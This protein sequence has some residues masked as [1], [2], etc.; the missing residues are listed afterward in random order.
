VAPAS[1]ADLE[2]AHTNQSLGNGHFEDFQTSNVAKKY[3]TAQ[4]I[5]ISNGTSRRS[6]SQEFVYP[7]RSLRFLDQVNQRAAD[8]SDCS[9]PV[10]AS[11]PLKIIIAGAG[12]GGL[13][14]AIALARSGHS[15]QV[16]E[17]AR[18]L[19]EVRQCFA[20]GLTK[21]AY[22]SQQVGAG[23]QIPSN[24]TRILLK[25]G[26]GPHLAA[27]VVEPESINFRR[28]EDGNI[29]G[30]TK[31]TPDFRQSFD[32]PYYVVHRAHFHN[33]MYQL[34]KELGVEVVLDAKISYYD[35]EA[36]AVE[37]E[38]GRIHK[39]DLVIAADGKS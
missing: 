31:L 13:A 3:L 21:P 9:G 22:F 26:L 38:N 8:Q 24:S 39:A 6:D 29:I 35:A 18:A 10:K 4:A 5:A 34:A 12:L 1:V 15:V 36:P 16:F 20:S 23:I 14:T 30:F 7:T 11:L 19:G 28:W 25:W 2:A 17:Q 27:H 33:A 32:A 37:L